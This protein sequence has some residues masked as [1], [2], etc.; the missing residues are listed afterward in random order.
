MSSDAKPL[1]GWANPGEPLP[2]VIGK[3]ELLPELPEGGMPTVDAA[4]I[5]ADGSTQVLIGEIDDGN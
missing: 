1:D 3:G 2:E 4:V 5:R